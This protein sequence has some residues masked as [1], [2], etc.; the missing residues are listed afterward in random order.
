MVSVVVIGAGIGGIATASRLARHG[1]QVAVVEKNEQAGGRCGRLDKDGH[2]LDTGP[3]LFLMPE[4][5]AQTFADLGERIVDHLDLRRIDPTYHIHFQ[6]GS[7]LALT[8]DL[9]DMHAQLEAIEAGSF[10]GF[11][12]YLHEGYRHYELG[13]AHLVRRSFNS[14]LDYC[15]L[16]NLLLLF[17]LRILL[18]H[19]DNIGNYF[20]DPRLKAAF[21]F[22]DMYL[23]D[24]PADVSAVFSLLPYSELAHGVWF[25]MGGM[26]RIIEA[27][28]GIA[29]RWGV[30]F[31]FNAAVKQ[32][33]VDNRRATGVT[34]ADGRRMAADVVVA[35]ADLPY[36]YRCLLPD[37][38]A[39]DQLQRRQYS[40]STLM[41]YWGV[42]K[43]YPQFHPHNLF[44]AGDYCAGF[45][46]IVRGLDLPEEASF[47][48]H[49]PARIDP[50]LAPPG[51]DT[52][53]VAVPVGHINPTAP[54]NWSAIQA[55][56]RQSV[57]QRLKDMGI[58]D[59]ADHI[60]FE[61]CVTP[62][63]WQ[64]KLNLTRGASHGLRHNMMQMAYLRPGNRH[65]RYRNLYFVGASTHPGTGLPTVLVSARLAA[66]R[67]LRDSGAT[68]TMSRL[69]PA[70]TS[71]WQ[72]L[73]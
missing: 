4:L 56:A 8:S 29:E 39:T 21:T 52:L 38:G 50:T 70:S 67:I 25:P 40:C 42:S 47:Y 2:R 73:L 10:G 16:R 41:F 35:N 43:R 72:V 53:M 28:T 22:Q 3:S 32:I 20:D 57:M 18:K 27:L 55:K 15:S 61:V 26:Y 54:Q 9:N 5:Y 24:S 1:F 7:S 14:L 36:V 59:L 69:V 58:G 63:D 44:L 33:D 65:K 46:R 11:L 49:A 64:D 34:L 68:R 45:D 66:E 13:L 60:K 71:S 51:Q 31:L 23:G 30:R 37:E 6:D 62:R 19:Y 12:R 48:V 17:R